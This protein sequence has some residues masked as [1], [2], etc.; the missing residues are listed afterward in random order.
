MAVL[1]EENFRIVATCNSQVPL[2]RLFEDAGHITALPPRQTG[3]HHASS[4]PATIND[5]TVLG[6]SPQRSTGGSLDAA[7]GGGGSTGNIAAMAGG[8][9]SSVSAVR[10]A[11]SAGL[12]A[13]PPLPPHHSTGAP[14]STHFQQQGNGATGGER[15]H[16]S[17]ATSLPAAVAGGLAGLAQRLPGMGQR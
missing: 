9:F 14:A 15:P 1:H 3:M 13:M 11:G 8:S 12:A 4:V 2:T 17:T 6:S 5:D 16:L 7:R 10:S